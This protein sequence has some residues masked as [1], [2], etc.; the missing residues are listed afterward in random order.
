M[1]RK[2]ILGNLVP[3]RHTTTTN[4]TLL[5][6]T[7]HINNFGIRYKLYLW[8]RFVIKLKSS[9]T[10]P[11]YLVIAIEKAQ[12][13]NKQLKIMANSILKMFSHVSTM[14]NYGYNHDYGRENVIK[15]CYSFL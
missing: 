6:E 3:S 12:N 8:T 1:A 14:S 13:K 4:K 11:K 15:I 7:T 2:T 9:L 10:D 5:F